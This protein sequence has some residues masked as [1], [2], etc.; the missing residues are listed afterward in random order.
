VEFDANFNPDFFINNYSPEVKS[1]L[2]FKWNGRTGDEFRDENRPFRSAIFAFVLNSG[3]PAPA[4]LLRDLLVEETKY[5]KSAAANGCEDR[6][7][8]ANIARIGSLLLVRTKT[9]Y[10]DD[11]EPDI[12]FSDFDRRNPWN[13]IRFDI[14]E[15]TKR[16]IAKSLK[17]R[18]ASMTDF[19][20]HSI[21]SRMYTFFTGEKPPPPQVTGEAS[22]DYF[23]KGKHAASI[24]RHLRN[25]IE[26]TVGWE[27]DWEPPIGVS[28][29]GGLPNLPATAEWPRW[30]GAALLFLAQFNLADLSPYDIDRALPPSGFLYFFMNDRMVSFRDSTAKGQWRVL[31]HDAGPEDL[32]A[33]RRPFDLGAFYS[34]FPVSFRNRMDIPTL[35]SEYVRPLRLSVPER[36]QYRELE[37]AR[38]RRPAPEANNKLLGHPDQTETDMQVE[39]ALLANGVDPTKEPDV[40]GDPKMAA[41]VR[42]FDDWLLLLQLD[43]VWDNTLH[44]GPTGKLFFWINRRDLEK[45]R[46]DNVRLCFQHDE[47]DV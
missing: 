22:R 17:T 3:I 33:A 19:E 7:A 28:K 38:N 12:F 2:A 18:M 35:D 10:I 26:I 4:E 15:R 46:F 29:I 9:E 5:R 44:D 40:A 25:A 31:Y 13:S 11:L 8:M 20:K 1:K 6:E 14:P 47:A 24:K 34:P 23:E 45:R 39:C 27:H 43:R 36:F 37:K 16:E 41:Y 30:Q 42:Q 32:P 21:Y